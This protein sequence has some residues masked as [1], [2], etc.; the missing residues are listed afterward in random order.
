[1]FG[2]YINNQR[3]AHQS[4]QHDEREEEGNQPGV[5]E[6]GVLISFLLLL[7][8][9]MSSQRDVCLGAVDPDLLGRVPVPRGGVHCDRT[10]MIIVRDLR[11]K[12]TE[13]SGSRRNG[14]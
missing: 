10:G 14:N 8:N 12:N 9:P 2:N 5:R 7:H 3:V 11:E 1:M 6:E 4:D 13:M